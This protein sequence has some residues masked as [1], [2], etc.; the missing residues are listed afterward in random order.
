MKLNQEKI[1]E[2]VAWVEKNGIFPQKA[3]ASIKSFCDAMGIDKGTYYQWMKKATFSTAIKKANETFRQTSVEE[4]KNALIQKALGYKTSKSKLTEKGVSVDGKMTTKEAVRITEDVT[5]PPDTGAAI[6]VLTNLDPDNW[7]NRKFEELDG[8]LEVQKP[9]IVF[10]DEEE[11][12]Q[13]G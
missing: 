12:E 8:S 11:E 4:I 9:Q 7:K 1:A 2:C 5:Y 10:G 3:G 6:F 13:D